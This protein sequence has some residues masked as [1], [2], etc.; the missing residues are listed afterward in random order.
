MD[1]SL[2]SWLALREPADFAARSATLAAAT[3]RRLQTAEPV[4]VVDL[5]TGTGS[6]LRYLIDRL[7]P[8][9]EWLV[10]DRDRRL[11]DE[12]RARMQAWAIARAYE[13]SHDRDQLL[14]RRDGRECR[15]ATRQMDLGVLADDRIFEGRHLVTASALLDLVSVEWLCALANHCRTHRCAALFALSYNGESQSLP[16]EQEDDEIRALMNRHQRT[17][18]GFAPAAGPEASA[19]AARAFEASGF[20]V[21]RERTNWILGPESSELQREL[22]E[23][24]ARAALEIAPENAPWIR[25]WLARRLDHLRQGHSQIVVGHE[26]L[27]AWPAAGP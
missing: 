2:S 6:N 8:R 15:I 20:D 12:V 19:A 23:G 7:S 14:L 11:L 16:L 18:K 9:Q 13:V 21:Q 24:W 22:I 3:A 26:D 10:V 17:D 4:R 5:G 27:A 1:E 25:D